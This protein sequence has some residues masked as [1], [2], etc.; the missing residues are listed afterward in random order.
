MMFHWGPVE[1]T[2]FEQLKDRLLSAPI[3]G[4]PQDTGVWTLDTDASDTGVGV[5]VSQ[6]QDGSERVISYASRTL[7]KT[8]KN[9]ST[10]RRELL[11]IVYG[12]YMSQEGNLPLVSHVHPVY[13]KG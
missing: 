10:T 2:A 11:A 4:I 1:Q 3:L 8:E 7:S 12:H 9:Y 5:V 13:F 6:T